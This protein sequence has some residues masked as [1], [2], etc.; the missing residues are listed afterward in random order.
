MRICQNLENELRNPLK[1]NGFY[2]IC[3][4]F[5]CNAWELPETSG[6]EA[7]PPET[8]GKRRNATKRYEKEL[9][10]T[11]IENEAVKLHRN[12]RKG[13]IL[14]R[15]YETTHQTPSGSTTHRTEPAERTETLVEYSESRGGGSNGGCTR[16]NYLA[17]SPQGLIQLFQAL[18][19]TFAEFHPFHVMPEIVCQDP[20]V[21][22]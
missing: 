3:V 4:E 15:H 12:G 13:K 19:W 22:P 11:T 2:E 21:L 16:Q 6:I 18:F 10:T 1:A 5:I 9:T 17:T 8:S 20:R 7:D 14:L